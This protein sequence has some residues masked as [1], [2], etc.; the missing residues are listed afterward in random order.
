MAKISSA[1]NYGKTI[2]SD[3]KVTIEL[4]K[5]GGLKIDLIS[6]VKEYFED[7]IISLAKNE[8]DFFEIKNAKIL[9]EDRGALDYVI[10]AR[11]E[12]LCSSVQVRELEFAAVHAGLAREVPFR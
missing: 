6:K 7:Q 1:G 8:L 10:A 3:C 9:I 5:S 12:S 11:I 2:R 4:T